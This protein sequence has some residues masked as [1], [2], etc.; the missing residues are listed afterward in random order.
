MRLLLA[1]DEQDLSRAISAILKHNG[2]VVDPVYDGLTAIKHLDANHYDIVI[3]DIMMPGADGIQVLK[4]FRERDDA[5]PVIMLTAK[6]EIDDR[7]LGLDSGA[8]DY[9]T[10]PFD[11]K[12]LLARLR[13]LL[14]TPAQP[15]A[16]AEDVSARERLTLGNLTLN[17]SSGELSTASGSCRLANKEFQMMELFLANANRLISADTLFEKVWGYDSDTEISVVWVYI[18][19]LRKKLGSLSAN[20]RIR[21]AR[22]MGYVMEEAK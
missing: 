11:M 19:T 7:V 3:L 22:G 12:E 9:L 14:R 6:A 15:S 8:N 18:S 17:L 2:Y 5:T 13:A 1:E 16:P 20:V 4:H 21:A 10:K